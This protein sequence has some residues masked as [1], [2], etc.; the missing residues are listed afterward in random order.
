MLPLSSMTRLRVALYSAR[1]A[2]DINV[3]GCFNRAAARTIVSAIAGRSTGDL[4]VV[5]G[6]HSPQVGNVRSMILTVLLREGAR[7]PEKYAEPC[8]ASYR[9][10]RGRAARESVAGTAFLGVVSRD[11]ETDVFRLLCRRSLAG[12]MIVW[13][14]AGLIPVLRPDIFVS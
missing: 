4:R 1:V 2:K 11:F 14:G 12:R 6:A 9:P 8:N 13:A 10:E 5:R 7:T 3:D